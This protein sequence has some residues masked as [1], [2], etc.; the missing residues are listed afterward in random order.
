M[1]YFLTVDWCK[2][3]ARGIFCDDKGRCFR[4]DETPHSAEEMAEILGPFFLV[5]SPE[6][7][8]YSRETFPTSVKWRPL[9]EYSNSYGIAVAQEA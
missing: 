8:E 5:L 7:L 9:A 2:S 6:S 1:P 3:G 4:K